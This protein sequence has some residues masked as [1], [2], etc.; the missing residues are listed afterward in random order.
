MW[1]RTGYLNDNTI[2]SLQLLFLL[3]VCWHYQQ[4]TKGSAPTSHTL[5]NRVNRVAP[6]LSSGLYGE[7]GGPDYLGIGTTEG[8]F[9]GVG[10][11]KQDRHCMCNMKMKHICIP[12][13]AMCKQLV[14]HI[15]FFY[16]HSYPEGKVDISYDIFIITPVKQL[17]L[18]LETYL[19]G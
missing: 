11:I 10:N 5:I 3:E 14:L 17:S 12:S 7:W 16:S 8:K 6:L 19:E 15:L 4:L 9:S 13:V 2:Q 1:H 18:L